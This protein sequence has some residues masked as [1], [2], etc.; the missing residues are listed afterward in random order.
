MGEPLP[1]TLMER[2]DRLERENRWWKLLG[3]TAVA[4]LSLVVLV[5]A[6]GDKVTDEIRTRQLVLVDQ[7]GTVLATL[8]PDAAGNPRLEL[9][10]KTG[11]GKVQVGMLYAAQSEQPYIFFVED[12]KVTTMLWTEPGGM[13]RL[14]LREDGTLAS[15]VVAPNG[16]AAV[17]LSGRGDRNKVTLGAGESLA[18]LLF[19]AG[20]NDANLLVLQAKPDGAMGLTL[21][22]EGQTRAELSVGSNSNVAGLKFS[23]QRGKVRAA[24]G[25]PADPG[26]PSLLLLSD[27][28]GKLI[29]TAP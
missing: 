25:T 18:T 10:G 21:Q 15:L 29:W 2:L 4:V 20:M 17:D 13:K 14:D 27:K 16:T 12:T 23:D 1:H 3:T 5:G 24:V 26:Q 28:D 11:K 9:T 8:G 6:T 22:M 19:N 7:A